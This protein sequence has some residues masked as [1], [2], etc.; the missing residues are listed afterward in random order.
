MTRSY[1]H[2]NGVNANFPPSGG[3]VPWEKKSGNKQIGKWLQDAGYY[4][5]HI[6]KY[7]NGYAFPKPSPRESTDGLV[8]VAWIGGSVDVSD[9]RIPAQ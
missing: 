1:P 2:N 9:V 7:I 8:G 6:G 5:A 3:F 4:T